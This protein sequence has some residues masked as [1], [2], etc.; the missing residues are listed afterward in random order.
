MFKEY[1]TNYENPSEM[2][3]KLRDTG[4][5][6]NEDQVHLIKEVLNKM[7][8]NVSENNTFVLLK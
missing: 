2:S 8:K 7:K 3:K 6:K 5:K 1:F 4:R